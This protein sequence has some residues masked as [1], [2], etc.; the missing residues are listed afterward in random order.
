MPSQSERYSLNAN[1]QSKPLLSQ[2]PAILTRQL[3]GDR[4]PAPP[5]TAEAAAFYL[6]RWAVIFQI[7]SAGARQSASRIPA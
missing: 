6:A 5:S 7:A 2:P 1:E 4:Q 3:C